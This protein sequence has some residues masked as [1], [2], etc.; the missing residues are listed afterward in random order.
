MF[1]DADESFNERFQKFATTYPVNLHS[2]QA[3]LDSFDPHDI[4]KSYYNGDLKES[5]G[6]LAFVREVA[7]KIKSPFWK[8]GVYR[9]IGDEEQLEIA[10]AEALQNPSTKFLVELTNLDLDSE[11]LP[12]G[13]KAYLDIAKTPNEKAL[14]GRLFLLS[15]VAGSNEVE[16]QIKEHR[17][18]IREELKRMSKIQTPEAQS[19]L[20]SYALYFGMPFPNTQPSTLRTSYSGITS[21]TKKTNVLKLLESGQQ[22]KAV[23][24]LTEYTKDSILSLYEYELQELIE[25]L[26]GRDE[27]FN[28]VLD[29]LQQGIKNDVLKANM[30]Y[31]ACLLYNKKRTKGIYDNLSDSR[32]PKS[33]VKCIK[34]LEGFPDSGKLV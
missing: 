6:D 30:Y 23:L 18:T 4:I 29:V 13:V 27:F 12:K 26:E 3:L 2:V 21:S 34:L 15:F 25:S 33:W 24:R 5:E 1:V 7:P 17:L 28:E 16:A 8:Y 9:L 22:E 14:A 19:L 11:N 20:S 32:L 31:R 10:K